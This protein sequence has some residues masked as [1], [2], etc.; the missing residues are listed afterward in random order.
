MFP[1]LQDSEPEVR[2]N[3]AFAIGALVENTDEVLGGEQY[4][5]LLGGL[6]K[7]FEFTSEPSAAEL[8]A[9]DNAAGAVSRMIIK[10][11]SAVPVAQVRARSIMCPVIPT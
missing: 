10:N 3:A 1:A 7:F 9:R 5:Q 2:S 8:N 6:S 11:V 4:S